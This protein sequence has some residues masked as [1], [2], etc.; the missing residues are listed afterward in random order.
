MKKTCF[1]FYKSLKKH[2]FYVF[3]FS[4]FSLYFFKFRVFVVVKTKTYKITN[5]MHFSW[6]KLH[7]LDKASVL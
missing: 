4:M 1:V 7:F 2:V 5:I 3:Y 6:S